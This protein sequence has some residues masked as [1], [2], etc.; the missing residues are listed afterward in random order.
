M[1]V[2]NPLD[3]FILNEVA[4]LHMEYIKSGFMSQL[5]E[6]FLKC[7][8][9]TISISESSYLAVFINEKNEVCG[10]ISGTVSLLNLKKDF[11]KKCKLTIV[12]SFL[13]LFFTPVKILNFFESYK[14]ASL[15]PIKITTNSE[16]ISIVVKQDCRNKGIA[17]ALYKSLI[18]FFKEKKV[19]KFKI[20]VGSNLKEAQKFYEKMGA[21]KKGDIEIHKGMKSFLYIHN[22]EE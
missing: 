22:I 16:L 19:K 2:I 6:R 21:E 11:K 3:E 15:E 9:R 13:K 8:Y 4:K 17:K 20:L 14:Y 7:F 10:F 18:H 12:S 1:V 5:G